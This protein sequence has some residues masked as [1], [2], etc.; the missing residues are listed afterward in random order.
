MLCL[1]L[2]LIGTIPGLA[3]EDVW[4]GVERVVAV[5][6]VHGDLEHL[7]KVLRFA[8]LIDEEMN[9]SGGKTHLVQTGDVLDRGPAVRGCLDLL[10]KLETQAPKQGGRVHCLLGNHEGMNL[11]GDLRYVSGA[12]LEGFRGPK[13]KPNGNHPAGYSEYRRDLGPDGKYGRWIR[14]HNTIIRI[15]GTVFLH[16]GISPKYALWSIRKIN[17]QVR[18]ELADLSRLPGGTVQDPDGPVW[19][20]GLATGDELLLASHVIT[21][22]HV[23]KADRMVVSHT[24]TDGA[25]T[26]RFDGKV[27]LIDIGLSRIYDEYIRLAC[28][29]IENGKPYALHN[30][31]RLELPADGS[32]QALLRYLKAASALDPPPSS[33]TRR[34][35][36]LEASIALKPK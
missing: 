3:A 34:I 4:Q 7:V 28:L 2:A 35:A 1:G 14:N 23:L 21:T 27:L 8:G 29:V 13:S 20:R 11:Y 22:L 10:M 15:D 16:G 18:D 9:W 26:P 24:F 33:L 12:T 17:E 31:S 19:Y 6:D 36:T 25:V 30:G 32:A 5:G